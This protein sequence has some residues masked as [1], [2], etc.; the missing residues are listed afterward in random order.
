MEGLARLVSESMARHGVEC[1]LD[2]RRLHWSRWF[3]CKTSFDLLLVPAHPGL[4][5]V[6][7]Q[8][9]A[10]PGEP[11]LGRGKRMLAVLQISAT[12]DLAIATA[13]LFAPNH[14]LKNRLAA[15]RIFVRYTVIED[16]AQRHSAQ[17]T[18]QRWLTTSTEADSGIINDSGELAA[19]ASPVTEQEHCPASV[20]SPALLSGGF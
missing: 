5:A 15:G 17:T 14:P 20:H 13:R 1:S 7:E 10:P 4:F 18:F 12:G 3:R 8:L 6:A 11:V 2:Y 16:D 19:F 9:I